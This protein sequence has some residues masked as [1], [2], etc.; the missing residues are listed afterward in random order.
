MKKLMSIALGCFLFITTVNIPPA[1]GK[2]AIALISSLKGKVEVQQALQK[3]LRAV[4]LG[5]RLFEDDVLYTYKNAKAS[6]LFSNGSVMTISSNSR[7]RLSFNGMDIKKKDSVLAS[8]SKGILNGMKGLFSEKEK[9]RFKKTIVA[10]I[11]KKTEEEEKSIRVLYPRNSMILTSKPTFHWKTGG[12]DELFMLTITLKGLGGKLWTIQ[13]KKTEIPY[14]KGR[15][16]LDRGQTYF[17]RIESEKDSS[18]YD[19]VYFRILDE[20][21][22]REVKRFANV[23]ERLRKSSPGDSSPLFISAGY[24][25]ERGL[26]HEALAALEALEKENPGERFI[27]EGKREIYATL[28]LWKRWEAVNQKI[29]LLK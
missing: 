2:D 27:F 18:I 5:E 15:K 28:G 26:Y 8:L 22:A 25:K 17:L 29:N 4:R 12:K 16:G 14:P 24:Y 10:G 7:L 11:R 9:G 21:K 3:G 1:I 6:V 13:T 23:M 19:E 20:E